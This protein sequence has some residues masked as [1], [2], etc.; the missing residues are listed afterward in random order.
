MRIA[1]KRSYHLI[2][3]LERFSQPNSP[4]NNIPCPSNTRKRRVSNNP[5][6]STKNSALLNGYSHVS[7]RNEEIYRLLNNCLKKKNNKV[8]S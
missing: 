1:V 5:I 7:V 2:I 6:E 3:N 8:Y 4:H